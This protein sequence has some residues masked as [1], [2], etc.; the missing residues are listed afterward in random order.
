MT[1]SL[2]VFLPVLLS[3]IDCLKVFK[4]VFLISLCFCSHIVL[5][6]WFANG[7]GIYCVILWWCSSSSCSDIERF[8]DCWWTDD[9]LMAVNCS[10]WRDAWR[11]NVLDPTGGRWRARRYVRAAAWKEHSSRLDGLIVCEVPSWEELGDQASILRLGRNSVVSCCA[12]CEPDIMSLQDGRDIEG[13]EYRT[14]RQTVD[15][16]YTVDKKFN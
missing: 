7:S 11:W 13:W 14:D 4:I 6:Q 15:V 2:T 1:V 10:M 9:G 8:I 3:L 12:C 5:P 16:I